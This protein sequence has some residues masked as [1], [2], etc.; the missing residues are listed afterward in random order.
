MASAL[1][2]GGGESFHFFEL[3]AEL[4]EDE[5]D[6]GF[7]ELVEAFGDLFCGA[8]E[9][10]AEAA[11]GDGIVFEGDALLELCTCQ[12]LLVIGVASG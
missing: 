11:V 9:A 2:D 8:D 3:G 7:F 12:P 1:D 4:E 10:G 6:A 5:V